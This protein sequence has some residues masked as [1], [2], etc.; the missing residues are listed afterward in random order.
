MPK[1]CPEFATVV[2]AICSAAPG[3]ITGRESYRGKD[4]PHA[5][6]ITMLDGR[7]Y[8]IT[9]S[10]ISKHSLYSLRRLMAED[11]TLNPRKPTT[12]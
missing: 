3:E 4:P 5:E 7:E 6:Y 10:A 8:K 9:V 12:D 2:E 11:E 1:N